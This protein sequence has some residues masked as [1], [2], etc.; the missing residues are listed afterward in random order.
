K[1]GCCIAA[2]AD[3]ADDCILPACAVR[4]DPW[5]GDNPGDETGLTEARL[6]RAHDDY[7][8]EKRRRAAS[9]REI[10]IAERRQSAWTSCQSWNPAFP[11]GLSAAHHCFACW[12]HLRLVEFAQPRLPCPE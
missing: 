6:S 3:G 7:L 2:E 11:L 4:G 8:I 1:K 12:C 10:K 9:R 5:A